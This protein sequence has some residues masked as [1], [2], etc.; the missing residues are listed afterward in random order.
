MTSKNIGADSATKY[1]YRTRDLA[2]P[3]VKAKTRSDG[4]IV[5]S[6]GKI[7]YADK[8]YVYRAVKEVNIQKLRQ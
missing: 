2:R 4:K 6:W 3:V 5:L 1:C 7:K 8:Y